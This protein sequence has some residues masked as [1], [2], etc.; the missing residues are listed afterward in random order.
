MPWCTLRCDVE[1]GRERARM[2]YREERTREGSRVPEACHS[3]F[4][5]GV[6]G[7]SAL[8]TQRG[9]RERER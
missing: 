3:P 6:R 1:D 5:V 8:V 9:R 4:S 2:G 7:Q